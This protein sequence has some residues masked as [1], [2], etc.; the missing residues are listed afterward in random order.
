MRSHLR[1]S[2]V[3]K[4]SHSTSF[5]SESGYPLS[6]T[7]PRSSD[8]GTI[9]KELFCIT[10]SEL[11]DTFQESLESLGVLF[12]DI[13]NT[14][15][16]EQC[17]R[18]KLFRKGAFEDGLDE[19]ERGRHVRSLELFGRGQL[20]FLVRQVNKS[21]ASRLQAVGFRFAHATNVIESLARSMQVP[22]ETLSIRLDR[23][24]G[25]FPKNYPL[26]PG[27]YLG[28][29]ALRPVYQQGFE[30]LVLKDAKYLMPTEPLEVRKLERWHLRLLA[31]MENWTVV[32]CC[33]HLRGRTSTGS[34]E[35][36]MF[37]QAL[38]DGITRLA[39]QIGHP[40]FEEARLITTPFCLPG[41][42]RGAQQGH[43]G[44]KE[45]QLIAFRIITDAHQ[46]RCFNRELEYIPSRFFLCQQRVYKNSPDNEI[47]C[48]KLHQDFATTPTPS[49]SDSNTVPTLSPRP[50]FY[51][52]PPNAYFSW[53][54]R[55]S[56]S[57][58]ER[59]RW[60]LPFSSRYGGDGSTTTRHGSQ[61][62]EKSLTGGSPERAAAAAG[63]IHVSNE[64]RVNISEVPGSVTT[65]DSEVEMACLGTRSEVGTG[66]E[67]QETF[68]DRLMA[69]TMEERRNQR[70]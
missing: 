67:E 21:E 32:T 42:T 64:I 58:S 14:G 8:Y 25:Y 53:A 10:A 6:A 47:F 44:Q 51:R 23:M 18:K 13:M 22:R 37:T 36:R 26:E 11:A 63:Q 4:P 29:F 31:E 59:R 38:L 52:Q 24:R 68:A 2:N 66:T 7:P 56:A 48:R 46:A 20:L 1:T 34:R 39:F 33:E 35:E 43:Q 61:S 55:A 57:P 5:S 50:S 17:K 69:L 3:I 16:T 19:A 45:T 62:S 40:F 65:L 27:T 41:S 49:P 9:F 54:R 28:C 12:E 15:T 60:A 30:V 70:R